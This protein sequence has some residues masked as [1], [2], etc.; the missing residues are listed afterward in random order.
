M[1][2]HLD[3]V[4][5][6]KQVRCELDAPLRIHENDVPL[7]RQLREY[8]R[9]RTLGHHLAAELDATPMGVSCVPNWAWCPEPRQQAGRYGGGRGALR[10]SESLSA[11]AESRAS[12]MLTGHGEPYVEG[13][14]RW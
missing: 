12:T 5:F 13:I 6:A 11:L 14:S 7:T 2:A 4:D 10:V 9:E 8:A 1:Q 3:H